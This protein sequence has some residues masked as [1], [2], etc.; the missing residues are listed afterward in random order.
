MKTVLLASLLLLV[1][2]AVAWAQ[3]PPVDTTNGKPYYILLTDGSHIQGRIIRRDSMM[4]T[5]R[6]KN[7]QLTYVEKELLKQLSATAP[8]SAD[9]AI[10]YAPLGS[11]RSVDQPVSTTVSPSTYEITLTDGT[12]LNAA[13]ISQDSSRVVVKNEALGTVY[14]PARRVVRMERPRVPELVGRRESSSG[15]PNLF[16]QYLNLLP[17][18]YQAERGRV[19]YRNTALYFSQFDVGITDNWSVGA[20]F[21][22]FV[23][24]LF[25]AFTTK[26]SAPLGPRV[27]IGIQA[28]LLYGSL[29][30]RTTTT[31]FLQ[32]LV[33]VGDSQNNITVGVGTG[34]SGNEPVQLLSVSVVRKI[35][36][37]LTFISENMLLLGGYNVSLGKLGAGLRFDRQRHSFDL[38]VN[39]PFGPD[40]I[41]AGSNLFFL[42]SASYQVRI[43]K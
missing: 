28:Q 17:S 34:T 29:F 24:T 22:T 25:G 21:F 43:G 26:L 3:A 38:S 18:A 1:T 4:Y 13:V 23:P 30:D 41:M 31:G 15:N 32:G 6:M 11:V 27:R 35:R 10:Y 8:V 40:G 33:S 7:G 19:Y 39:I 2:M 37:S 42:P 12:R 16:P 36:P 20:T 9:T 5:V 14:I